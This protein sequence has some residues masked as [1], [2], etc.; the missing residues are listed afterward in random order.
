M[1]DSVETRSGVVYCTHDGIELAGDLFLPA[2]KGPFPAIIAVH[3]VCGQ[4]FIPQ[5]ACSRCPAE[6]LPDTMEI[7]SPRRV[8][9]AVR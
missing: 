7:K 3:K 9:P 2:G 1:A 4:P 6:L 8:T 5:L